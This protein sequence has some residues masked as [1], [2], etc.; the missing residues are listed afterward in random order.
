MTGLETAQT[1]NEDG[2]ELSS[3]D[4]YPALKAVEAQQ[5]VLEAHARDVRRFAIGA[6]VGGLACITLG[7]ISESAEA[8][9]H[10]RRTFV[11]A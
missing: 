2:M 5:P 1:L 6:I 9:Y 10:R 3:D 11:T 4:L 7:T 8:I